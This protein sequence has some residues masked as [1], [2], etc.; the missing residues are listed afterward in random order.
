MVGQFGF[1]Q[2]LLCPTQWRQHLPLHRNHS[3]HRTP[4]AEV[5]PGSRPVQFTPCLQD[6]RKLAVKRDGSSDAQS[7]FWCLT[8]ALIIAGSSSAF[9]WDRWSPGSAAAVG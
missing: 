9:A 6:R 5:S 4:N 7:C 2:V 1:A 3:A 8:A